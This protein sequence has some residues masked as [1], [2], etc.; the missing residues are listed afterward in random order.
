MKVVVN[1]GLNLSEL[2]GWWA[3]AYQP[4]LGWAIGDGQEHGPEWDGKEA[5]QLY[6]LLEN[7]IVPEY[8]DRNEKGIPL[9]WVRRIKKNMCVLDTEFSSNRMLTDYLDRVYLPAAERFKLR[10]TQTGQL[11]REL[12]A[13][14]KS[15]LQSWNMIRFGKSR[16]VQLNKHWQIECEVF[17]DEL[18]PK[19][20]KVEIYADPSEETGPIL[21]TLQVM[22]SLSFGKGGYLYGGNVP[23]SRPI[24]HYSLRIIPDHNGAVI[25]L[26]DNHIL[27]RHPI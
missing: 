9:K 8:Y 15:L 3:E 20:I 13:W 4:D 25:P 2:D 10:T 17:I 23:S 18:T 22:N 6:D 16:A 19:M 24:E 21:E 5:E 27:W 1:G 26:E 14:Q 11:A 12:D 7:E